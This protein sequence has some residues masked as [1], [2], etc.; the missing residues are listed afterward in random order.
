MRPEDVREHVNKQ[1]FE[2]FRIYMSD[3]AT[4]DVRHPDLCLIGRSA[5]YVV[6][7]D[8]RRPWMYDRLAHCALI[9]ITRIEPVNGR[10][11]RGRRRRGSR[12][13]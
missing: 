9:H 11:G 2:P 1:P 8:T 10:N 4:F 7:P 6:I 12:G 13:R 3:G 5:V